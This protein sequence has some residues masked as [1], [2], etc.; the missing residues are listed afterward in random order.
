MAAM[1]S[2]GM[3]VAFTVSVICGILVLWLLFEPI[4]GDMDGFWECVKFD[5]IPDIISLFRG[6]YWEDVKA[7]FK[8]GIWFFL[9]F[10]GC[11]IPFWLT[12]LFLK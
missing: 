6:Q 10:L 7:S 3:A 5:F 9:G 2:I 12:T 1:I 8:L 11:I 4:F